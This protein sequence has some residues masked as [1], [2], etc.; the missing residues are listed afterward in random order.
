MVPWARQLVS[1]RAEPDPTKSL[2]GSKEVHQGLAN[3]LIRDLHSTT[4]QPLQLISML[5]HLLPP[6]NQRRSRLDTLALLSAER[7]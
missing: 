1:S 2:T 3:G 7:G 6:C 4:S 5:P